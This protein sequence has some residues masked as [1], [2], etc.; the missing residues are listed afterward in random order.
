MASELPAVLVALEERTHRTRK[1]CQYNEE[2]KAVLSKHKEEYMSKT[3]PTDR[4]QVL[5]TKILVDI[6]NYWSVKE[7]IVPT[8]DADIVTQRIKVLVSYNR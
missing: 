1:G 6:F 3:T 4:E 5:K 2:E 8:A 7:E